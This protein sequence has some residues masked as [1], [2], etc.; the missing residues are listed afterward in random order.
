MVGFLPYFYKKN[1]GGQVGKNYKNR[2]FNSR[3]SRRIFC[4]ITL[5]RRNKGRVRYG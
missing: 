1:G 4:I 5:I 2:E 3:L